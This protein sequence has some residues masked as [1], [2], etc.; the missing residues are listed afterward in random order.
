MKKKIVLILL[1][2][3]LCLPI[4]NMY[5]AEE[6]YTENIIPKMI[7]NNSPSGVASTN[8]EYSYAYKAFDRNYETI[9]SAWTSASLSAW[10]RYDFPQAQIVNQYVIYPQSTATTRAPKNWTFEGSN[11]GMKWDVLD[12]RNDISEW[13]NNN[14]KSFSFSNSKAYTMYRINIISNNGG[15]YLSLSELEM[16]G[17][18]SSIPQP[19]PNPDEEQP[20]GKRAIL[21]VTMT[22][23]LEKE[24]DLTMEEVN[25]FINWYEAKQ[26]GTGRASYA[27]DKHDNNKGPFK[28]RKDYILFNR[29][30]MF[31]VGEYDN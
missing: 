27:I 22:T 11:D 16:M 9:E 29:I 18:K 14:S 2:M 21:A 5:A 25:D 7:S 4:S 20:S 13:T 15:N 3:L 12:T 8:Y 28:S 6:E 1:T 17:T 19:E 26:A 23:G 31:E 10:L 24:Y 30:L